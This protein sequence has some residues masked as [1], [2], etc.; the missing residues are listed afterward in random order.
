MILMKLGA[1]SHMMLLGVGPETHT[2]GICPRDALRRNGATI[3][4][5]MLPATP[6]SAANPWSPA[7]A[8][9]QG[10]R[11]LVLLPSCRAGSRNANIIIL[12]CHTQEK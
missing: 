9:L 2:V 1:V 11:N 8:G 4:R 3:V 6:T 5:I 12:L 10:M 7:I